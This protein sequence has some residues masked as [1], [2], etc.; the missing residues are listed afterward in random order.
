M[1]TATRTHD[2]LSQGLPST[3]L[4]HYASQDGIRGI[5]GERELW[6]TNI[7]F[8]ND[9]SEFNHGLEIINK[10]IAAR[11][12]RKVKEEQSFFEW[13]DGSLARIE[14]ENVFVISFSQEHDL[15]SQWRGY[16]PI[17]RGFSIEFCP[18]NLEK[19]AWETDRMV[20]VKCVYTD[21][22]KEELIQS[23]ID[24]YLREWV[25][26]ARLDDDGKEWVTPAIADSFGVR[27]AFAAAAMKDFSF[28]EEREWR[29][30]K[31]NPDK[32]RIRF[33]NGDS[34]LIPY[35]ALNWNPNGTVSTATPIRSVTVGPCP[36]QELS[37]KSLKKLLA[38]HDLED[39]EI[40]QSSIPYRTW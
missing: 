11:R 18:A 10:V 3:S 9:M 26:S 27:M 29:L 17:N 30:I 36:N 20:L 6:A 19:T 35:I 21:D 24:R 23:L 33:R 34:F 13:H 40:H 7:E 2:P 4:H 31:A 15:L 1:T 16:T 38:S 14:S 37:M 28:S 39:V 32:N 12:S 22:E 5:V 8:L 25:A